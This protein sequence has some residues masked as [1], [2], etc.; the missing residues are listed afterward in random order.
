MKGG[1]KGVVLKK[2]PSAGTSKKAPVKP[3][4]DGKGESKAP[5]EKEQ[6]L[7]VKKEEDGEST[8]RRKVSTS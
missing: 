7:P 6:A 3:E 2:K 8:K 1:L 4:E 5:S